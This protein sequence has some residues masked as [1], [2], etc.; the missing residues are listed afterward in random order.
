MTVCMKYN[1]AQ[2]YATASQGGKDP[3]GSIFNDSA[4]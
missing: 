4:A 2:I 1:I 3:S